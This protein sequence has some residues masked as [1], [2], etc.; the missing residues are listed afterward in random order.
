MTANSTAELS[1]PS[2]ED[3][4]YVIYIR[5]LS[6]GGLGPASEPVR[7]HQ[8]SKTQGFWILEKKMQSI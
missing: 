1:L 4:D 3:E 6:E 2:E 7:I 8:Q 5:T